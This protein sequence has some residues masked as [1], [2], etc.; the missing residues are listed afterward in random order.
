VS[1]SLVSSVAAL[2]GACGLCSLGACVEPGG[3]A[4]DD[5]GRRALY[6]RADRMFATARLW[7]PA[8]GTPEDAAAPLAPLLIEEAVGDDPP[9]T[10]PAVHRGTS[11][12]TIHGRD[13]ARESYTWRD[14]ATASG[15]Q[16]IRLTLGSDGF[17]AVYE[18]LAD[19]SGAHVIFVSTS[20]ESAAVAEFGG[21]V[22][23]RRFAVERP[24]SEAPGVVVVS[25]IEP[26]PTPLGPFVYLSRATHDVHT[27]ICRC[28]PAQVQ[29]ILDSRDYPL[30]PRDLGAPVFP[31]GN[32]G[33][34]RRLR[35]PESI[36]PREIL[37]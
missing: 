28:M 25:E 4:L 36:F 7:K 5:A 1:R 20:V 18:V 11:T 33:L 13:Y 37:D 2:A 9:T 31:A 27:L 15:L 26:G 12:V 16:G 19:S 23:G 29:E 24:V 35:L 32:E 30:R 3:A 22:P 8:A 34:E 6:E 17:P 10:P 14:P 21:P